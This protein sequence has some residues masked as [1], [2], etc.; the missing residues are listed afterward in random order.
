M[1]NN[2]NKKR[3]LL[4]ECKKI[5]V[6]QK[7][8][9]EQR[10]YVSDDLRL[11]INNCKN[12]KKTPF[13]ASK[14]FD[15]PESTIRNHLKQTSASTIRGRPTVF[16]FDEESTMVDYLISLSKM[17]HGLDMSFKQ[18]IKDFVIKFEKDTPFKNNVP[19]RDW[20]AG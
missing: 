12:N 7:N 1:Y 8:R 13:K 20:I 4:D 10:E 3:K 17:G 18:V 19:G 5:T 2:N 14:E 9:E 15:I 11:A 6:S 16:T